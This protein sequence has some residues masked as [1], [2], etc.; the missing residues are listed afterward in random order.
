M[1]SA[2]VVVQV[3]LSVAVLVSAG[4]LA[5]TLRAFLTADLGYDPNGVVLAQATLQGGGESPQR[6][7]LV[8]EEI[9]KTFRSLPGVESA[10]WGR[11]PSSYRLSQ[12]TV[13][14]PGGAERR[15]GS[16]LNLIS[17]DFFKTWR[18]AMLAG[19]DFSDR[20][21][22]TSP[23]VAILS[24]A[25]A[26]ALFGGVNPVGLRFREEDGDDSGR[27]YSVEVVGVVRDI[28]YRRPDYGPLLILYRLYR[29]AG[30]PAWV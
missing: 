16:Y 18:A 1:N 12:L 15:M 4:L 10:S 26:K 19:R 6:E 3:A 29:N 25:L 11:V 7:V 17:S 21:T 30:A 13:P 27:G 9:L 28:Q 2:L 5:R 23:A 22:E 8:G 24:E 20:D 14:G